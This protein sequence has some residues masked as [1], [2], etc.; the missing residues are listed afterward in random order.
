MHP[1]SNIYYDPSHTHIYIERKREKKRKRARVRPSQEVPSKPLLL[2][3]ICIGRTDSAKS[4][5]KHIHRN[6]T[7]FNTTT[8]AKMVSMHLCDI[9][10]SEYIYIYIYIYI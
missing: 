7:L 6:D 8:S 9:F 10:E 3:S 2:I 1:I 4:Y 5:T